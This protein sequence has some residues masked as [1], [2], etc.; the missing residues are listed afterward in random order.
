MAK[1]GEK[2][3]EHARAMAQPTKHM[4]EKCGQV[5]TVGDM[6]PV[7]DGL[8]RKMMTLT[9]SPPRRYS[10]SM[11]PKPARPPSSA[12]QPKTPR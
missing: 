2:S 5:I 11:M 3:K 9:N 10:A 4:C 6:F 12:S 7:K 1:T 8:R